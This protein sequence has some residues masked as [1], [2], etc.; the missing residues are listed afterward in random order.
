[1]NEFGTSQEMLESNGE[2]TAA[3]E[4]GVGDQGAQA[5]TATEAI[6]AGEGDG[7]SETKNQNEKVQGNGEAVAKS[8]D[9]KKNE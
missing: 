1:M 8:E 5:S 9:E 6:K 4:E 2:V 3:G 7:D